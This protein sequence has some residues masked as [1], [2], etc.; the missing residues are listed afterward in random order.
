MAD[1]IISSLI[2]CKVFKIYK[3]L[4]PYGLKQFIVFEKFT[5]GF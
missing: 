2:W 5:R 1:Y 3:P 4:L